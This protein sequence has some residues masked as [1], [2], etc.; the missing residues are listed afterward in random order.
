M[1]SRLSIRSA[2][3][4]NP[5]RPARLTM[6]IPVTEAA[7]APSDMPTLLVKNGIW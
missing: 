4:P 5:K 3:Y 7:A 1:T 2:R 6:T